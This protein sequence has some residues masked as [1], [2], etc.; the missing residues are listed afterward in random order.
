MLNGIGPMTR[1]FV[2]TLKKPTAT[3]VAALILC[4]LIPAAAMAASLAKIDIVP[5]TQRTIAFG[6]NPVYDQ[7]SSGLDVTALGVKVYMQ[8]VTSTS[9]LTGYQWRLL[10][11]PSGSK[12]TLSATTGTLTTLRPDVVG[13]Y[14]VALVPYL[15]NKATT[16]TTQLIRAATWAGVGTI[17]THATPTPRAPNCGT[18][19]CHGGS[20]GAAELNVLADWQKSGHSTKMIRDL[21]GGAPTYKASCLQCH[22]VGYDTNTAAVNGGFDDIAKS[23]NYDLT[24]MIPQLASAAAA[25]QLPHFPDLPAELQ[26]MANI[27]CEACH[28]AGTQHPANLADPDHGIAGTDL[29]AKACAQCHDASSGHHQ[30]WWQWSNTGHPTINTMENYDTS[31]RSTCSKC[32]SGNGFVDTQIKGKPTV[33][34]SKDVSVGATCVVCHDPHDSAYPNQLRISGDFTFD[35]GQSYKQ[36][37]GTDPGKGGMCMRCH[38]SRVASVATSVNSYRGAHYGTQGDMLAGINGYAFGLPFSANSAH[39]TV[40]QETC[41]TCHM[42]A[43]P[44]GVTPAKIG[45]HTMMMR[46]D[47]GTT[48]TADD[49][50]NVT[51]ACGSCHKGLTTYDRTARGDYDGDGVTEGIQSEVTGLLTM[52][53][54]AILAQFPGKATIDPVS[55]KITFSSTDYGKL[56]ANQKGA[57]YNYNFVV[58]D[59]SLGVHNPSYAVQLLQRAYT[60]FVGHSI[61]ADYPTIVLRSP[62][63]GSNDAQSWTAYN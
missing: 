3:L 10:S 48:D 52:L 49:A 50:I 1:S 22:T 5:V 8:A 63:K 40:T 59:G 25:E 60:N 2:P 23:I 47:K 24:T 20:N 18:G 7:I 29:S 41:V 15:A 36:V 6:G 44:A 31:M 4:G 45:A 61:G 51:A 14:Q 17:N 62:F 26:K 33:G 42:A 43:A 53:R 46:D 37:T 56:T 39:T 30:I 38:N 27:Q 34:Y 28:G 12:A 19:F 21:N 35:S 9:T 32:H 58:V 55:H 13:S 11:A 54:T 16:A 57:V